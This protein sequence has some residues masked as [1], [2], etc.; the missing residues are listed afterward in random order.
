MCVCA[1]Y[2]LGY[3]QMYT[4][5]CVCIHVCVWV[6]VCVCVHACMHIYVC[7]CACECG[8]MGVFVHAYVV[9]VGGWVNLYKY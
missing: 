5:V 3:V 4:C 1:D 7:V 8:W 9:S 6:C 2:D